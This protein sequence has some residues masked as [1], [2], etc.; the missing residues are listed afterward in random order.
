MPAVPLM[1]GVVSFVLAPSAGVVSEILGGV[2]SI[3]NV[4][5]ALNPV[6][7]APSDCCACAVYVPAPSAVVAVIVHVVPVRV[8]LSVCTGLPL[9]EEPL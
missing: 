5:G 3:V 6:L 2:G 9:T 8:A 1:A 7:P 4:C